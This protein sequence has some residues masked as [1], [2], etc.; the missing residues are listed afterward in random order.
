MTTISESNK[1]IFPNLRILWCLILLFLSFAV[2]SW[3]CCPSTAQQ[4]CRALSSSSQLP[5][6]PRTRS[7]NCPPEE[8]RQRLSGTDISYKPDSKHSTVSEAGSFFWGRKKRSSALATWFWFT[9]VQKM[10]EGLWN[11]LCSFSFFSSLLPS[12]FLPTLSVWIPWIPP[13]SDLPPPPPPTC[14]VL[15]FF[16]FWSVGGPTVRSPK[17]QHQ[18]SCTFDLGLHS[19]L[20]CEDAAQSWTRSNVILTHASPTQHALFCCLLQ[21]FP[22]YREQA[23]LLEGWDR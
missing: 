17:L 3:Q 11:F 5:W 20:I 4:S 8:Q 7:F 14:S 13:S 10:K 21:A 12:S 15:F 16:S 23:A 22:D 2:V 6:L 1:L 19:L 18:V 9:L